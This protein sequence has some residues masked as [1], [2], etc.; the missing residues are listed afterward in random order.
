M[1]GKK[2]VKE[3][4]KP[5]WIP[6]LGLSFLEPLLTF[7][8]AFLVGFFYSVSAGIMIFFGVLAL[9]RRMH[10]L[11][12]K[13]IS[14]LFLPLAKHYDPALWEDASDPFGDL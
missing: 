3:I 1:E 11:D 5:R 7:G 13:F 12:P 4:N 10:S 14:L 8:A 2:I 9:L 6:R